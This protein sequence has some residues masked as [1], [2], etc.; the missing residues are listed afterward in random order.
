VSA[1]DATDG[2]FAAPYPVFVDLRGR[3]AL[4]VG[5]GRGAAGKV[6]G[7]LR[8]GAHVTVVAPAAVTEIAEDPDVRW[9]ERDYRRG[10]IASYSIAITA[11]DDPAVN[12]QVARDAN[13]ANVWVNSA[14]DRENCTFILPS[15]V[16]RGDLQIAAS[17]NGRSPAMAQWVRRRLEATFTDVHATA[18]DLIAEV[19]AE[20]RAAYG[21]SEI[22]GWAAAID[23]DFFELVSAGDHE[24]ARTHLRATVLAAVPQRGEP[25]AN[26]DCGAAS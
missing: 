9:H 23:D 1:T 10:E 12:R 18:L 26:G 24:A 3:R 14:D 5:G 11:T 17:T 6:A 4:V 22:G 16:Q 15:V 21:T 13:A 2:V 19:R 8:A 20:V 7:L 25:G